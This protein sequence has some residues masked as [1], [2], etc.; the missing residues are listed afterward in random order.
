MIGMG[1][2]YTF[3]D[4]PEKALPDDVIVGIYQLAAMAAF[5]R[6][7][8]ERLPPINVPG[9][10]PYSGHVLKLWVPRLVTAGYGP[11]AYGIGLNQCGGLTITD[12]NDR[13]K[14]RGKRKK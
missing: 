12:I 8:V 14:Y 5:S 3:D 7:K 6:E 1:W 9:I 4:G 11:Y 13:A 2:R 10:E